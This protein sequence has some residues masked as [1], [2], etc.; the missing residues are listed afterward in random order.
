MPNLDK[1]PGIWH[2]TVQDG[3]KVKMTKANS[4]TPCIV[5]G[6]VQF[7][8]NGTCSKNCSDETYRQD[9]SHADRLVLTR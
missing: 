1:M 6:A 2:T 8:V 7:L 9:I 5:C 3:P 4:Q